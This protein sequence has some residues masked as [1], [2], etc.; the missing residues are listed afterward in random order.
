MTS[1]ETV[2]RELR[3]SAARSSA[4]K[5]GLHAVLAAVLW[6]ATVL[7]ITRL[8][9]VD[10]GTRLAALGIPIAFLL[11]AVGWVVMQPAKEIG[12]AHV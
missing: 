11:I 3:W 1:L 10:Q 6:V 7:L 2:V 4:P 12:R 9:P 5:F 8:T